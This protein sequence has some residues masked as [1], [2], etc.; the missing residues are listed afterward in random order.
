MAPEWRGRQS[1]PCETAPAPIGEKMKVGFPPA[2]VRSSKASERLTMM[3]ASIRK[4][5]LGSLIGS[6]TAMTAVARA[7]EPGGRRARRRPP[8]RG[9][10]TGPGQGRTGP[11]HG[12]AAADRL[13]S[14]RRDRGRPARAAPTG[15]PIDITV[16]PGGVVVRV[17]SL[18]RRIAI[19]RWDYPA[20][21]TVALHVLDLSQPTPEMLEI[22][23]GG[24]APGPARDGRRGSPTNVSV[25]PSTRTTP[26]APGACM[27]AWRGHAARS[28]PIPG[29]SR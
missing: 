19:A 24:P 8:A 11:G 4:I 26:A 6:L 20:L 25:Q 27:P 21:R 2:P 1:S 22:A 29:W 17:G 9:A 18:W 14:S 7:A 12:P 28:C 10:P 5:L 15:V 16:E 3:K 13:R 23:P